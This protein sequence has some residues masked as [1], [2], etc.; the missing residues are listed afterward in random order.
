MVK[1]PTLDYPCQTPATLRFL[2]RRGHTLLQGKIKPCDYTASIIW[3]TISFS[4]SGIDSHVHIEQ[5][6]HSQ[7]DTWETG[8][9]SALAG[10]NTTVLAF[11]AQDRKDTS[12]W[13][14][15]EK[16]HRLAKGNAFCDYGFHIILT[17][18]T[19]EILEE[20]LKAI[21]EREGIS[22]VK[23]YMT[24]DPL[25]LNDA[26]LL[27]IMMATKSLGM[28]TMVHAENHD[29]IDMIIK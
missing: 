4:G 27:D 16:Y 14:I 24:Y 19:R 9:K 5:G 7:G 29:M 20:E 28:T 8:T 21:V 6:D 11:A 26:E 12:L 3:L 17:N 13:P 25:K 18:P 23:L 15:L 10:G 2:T 22:S 1:L